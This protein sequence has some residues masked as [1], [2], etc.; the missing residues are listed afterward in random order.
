M[1]RAGVPAILELG[2]TSF[3]TVLPIPTSVFLPMVILFIILQPLP[4]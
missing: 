1:G 3:N 2:K 4:I